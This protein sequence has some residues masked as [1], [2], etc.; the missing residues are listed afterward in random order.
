MLSFNCSTSY[1]VEYIQYSRSTDVMVFMLNM[2]SRFKNRN[3]HS[4]NNALVLQLLILMII[5]ISLVLINPVTATADEKA[6]GKQN[7]KKALMLACI[8]HW[9]KCPPAL[10]RQ[11]ENYPPQK[12]AGL[13]FEKCFLRKTPAVE[14]YILKTVE[15]I[16]THMLIDYERGLKGQGHPTPQSI[17]QYKRGIFNAER[18]LAYGDQYLHMGNGAQAVVEAIGTLAILARLALQKLQREAFFWNVFETFKVSKQNRSRTA[19]RKDDLSYFDS[20]EVWGCEAYVKRDSADKLKQRSVKCIFVGYPKETMGYYFYFP[21][22]NKVIVARG[23]LEN[24]LIIG[25]A[26]I[27]PDKVYGKVQ[28]M[29]DLS[30]MLL[31]SAQGQMWRDCSKLGLFGINRIRGSIQWVAVSVDASWHAI[32]MI[33]KSQ[34]GYV[35]VV[36]GGAVDWKSKKQ[37]TIAMH[38]TQSEYMAASE[39]AM[40]AVWIRKFVEVLGVDLVMPFNK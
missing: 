2:G 4:D 23:I 14:I 19:T 32:M 16:Y 21:P 15:L 11:F 39:A 28:W 36:N 1:H 25:A 34:T 29:W 6:H 38:A 13:N 35:F 9:K 8:M 31:L 5:C 18:K 7:I 40:E 24:L 27:D 20:D 26:M 30:C 12:H 22:E 33:Q 10:Q 37:T 17:L 3:G